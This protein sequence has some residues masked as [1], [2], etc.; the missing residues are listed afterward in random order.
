MVNKKVTP[1][2]YTSIMYNP[3]PYSHIIGEQNS[4]IRKIYCL[5]S[6]L[7]RIFFYKAVNISKKG[8]DVSQT[9]FCTCQKLPINYGEESRP[10]CN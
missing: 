10:R 1:S 3:K 7:Q 9:F 5:K 6:R 8:S 4:P 2:S